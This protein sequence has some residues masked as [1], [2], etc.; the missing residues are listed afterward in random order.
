M[1]LD[2]NLLALSGADLYKYGHKVMDSLFNQDEFEKCI[3][4]P[5][6]NSGFIAFDKEKIELLKSKLFF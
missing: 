4:E 6:K 3:V 5:T 1:Y 2:I